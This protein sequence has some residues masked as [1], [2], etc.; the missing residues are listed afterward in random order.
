LCRV[1]LLIAH[2]H[3]AGFGAD[4]S[5]GLGVAFAVFTDEGSK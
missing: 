3:R 2:A 5:H 1:T 4:R